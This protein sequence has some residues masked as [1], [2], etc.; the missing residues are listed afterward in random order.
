M[1]HEN[2]IRLGLSLNINFMIAMDALGSCKEQKHW[3][4]LLIFFHAVDFYKY[5]YSLE[6]RR[7]WEICY[8]AKDPQASME[9][10]LSISWRYIRY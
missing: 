3:M 2:I 7:Q 6:W 10:E 1:E 8:R 9:K 4:Q 5:F